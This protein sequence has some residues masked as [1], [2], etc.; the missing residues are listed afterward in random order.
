MSHSMALTAVLFLFS[1]SVIHGAI[2]DVRTYT[3]PNWVSYG[4]VPL[5]F[6]FVALDWHHTYV[7]W[8]I[9]IGLLVFVLCIIFWKLRWMGGGDV[10]FVS[11]ISL[12]MGPE[13]I[14]LFTVLLAIGSAFLVSLLRVARDWGPVLQGSRWPAILKNMIAKA[15][16][17]AVPYGLPAA[18]A[19]LVAMFSPLTQ[20]ALL[21]N[22]SP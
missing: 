21:G 10:K 18:I 15:E 16:E 13:K 12:W 3:I 5:F 6:L 4:L 22:L 7:L 11:A 2:T 19:A 9:A 8:H 20:M 17:H 14:L 1:V